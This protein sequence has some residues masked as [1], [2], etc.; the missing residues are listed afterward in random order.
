M[1]LPK[2][3][4]HQ[5]KTMITRPICESEKRR[6]FADVALLATTIGLVVSLAI[7]ITTVSIGIARADTLNAIASDNS[8]RACLAVFF[9]LVL[10]GM[11]GVTAAVV[12]DVKNPKRCA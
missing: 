11:S 8:G 6:A 3:I 7:A 5:A 1:V 10:M 9:A 2:L 12:R 4:R